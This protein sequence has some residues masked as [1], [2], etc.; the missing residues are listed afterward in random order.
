MYKREKDLLDHYN[1]NVNYASVNIEKFFN[2]FD[3][4]DF[5]NKKILDLGCGDGRFCKYLKT[6]LK[7]NPFGIDF[8]KNRIDKARKQNLGINYFCID[9]YKYAEEYSV[10]KWGKFDLVLMTEVIEH[11]E[12]PARLSLALSRISNAIFGSVPLNFPYIAHL[13]VFENKEQFKALFKEWDLEIKIINR[14]I[15]FYGKLKR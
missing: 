15:Y 4:I 10:A 9:C 2:L 6:K 7:A 13:Q 8:S 1:N 12:N 11:L 3:K 14:N 5:E